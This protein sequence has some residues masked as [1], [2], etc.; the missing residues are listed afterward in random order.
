MSHQMRRDNREKG[1][2]WK[3]LTVHPFYCIGIF[4]LFVFSTLSRNGL[5][6]AWFHPQ[7]WAIMYQ[8]YYVEYIMEDEH[9]PPK[10]NHKE[11]SNLYK[12]TMLWWLLSTP[13]YFSLMKRRASGCDFSQ[14]AD[15]GGDTSSTEQFKVIFQDFSLTS[16]LFMTFYRV[17][18]Y[19][20]MVFLLLL[21]TLATTS[22]VTQ[23]QICKLFSSPLWYY[24]L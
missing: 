13:A 4:V 2:N 20:R 19:A 6:I 3:I 1:T 9:S 8:F 10:S 15:S 11:E 16:D 21:Y 24:M 17:V 18:L 12:A 23:S 14:R 22:I 7:F 5:A